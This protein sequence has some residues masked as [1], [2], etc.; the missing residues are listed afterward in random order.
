ML[1]S[2]TN[3]AS[4]AK[5]ARQAKQEHGMDRNSSNPNSQPQAPSSKFQAQAPDK[6]KKI[7]QKT[8]KDTNKHC[9]IWTKFNQKT[10][11]SR[12]SQK[13][14]NQNKSKQ[15]I[16][17]SKYKSSSKANSIKMQRN[18]QKLKKK[19]ILKLKAL[20]QKIHFLSV[21]RRVFLKNKKRHTGQKNAVFEPVQT[22]LIF[23]LF[24]FSFHKILIL[25]FPNP[26]KPNLNLT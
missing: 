4:Q 7:N 19:Q 15:I 17:K 2:Q 13:C 26:K 12:K 1:A 21:G 14:K 16:S 5:P 18:Q 11:K 3:Q 23:F 22:L 20:N 6:P 10:Q 8:K 25:N 9:K 24:F